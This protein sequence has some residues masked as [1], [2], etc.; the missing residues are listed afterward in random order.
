MPEME[1]VC[2]NDACPGHEW[3]EDGTAIVEPYRW[4][5]SVSYP[6]RATGASDVDPDCPECG[7]PGNE[8]GEVEA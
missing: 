1:F 4:W 6:D 2:S 8:T 3:S 5:T 7:S